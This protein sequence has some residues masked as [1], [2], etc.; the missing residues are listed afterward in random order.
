MRRSRIARTAANVG[1]SAARRRF[2]RE[3]GARASRSGLLA[4]RGGAGHHTAVSGAE[5]PRK[6]KLAPTIVV[7]RGF[8]HFY[9]EE[10]IAAG[11]VSWNRRR[12]IASEASGDLCGHVHGIYPDTGQ[13]SDR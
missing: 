6:R 3:R 12:S 9:Q 2:R 5:A 4:G 11:A 8:G 7:Q 13:L 1:A 10:N